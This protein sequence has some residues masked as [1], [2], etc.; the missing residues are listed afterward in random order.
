MSLSLPV[1]EPSVF[2]QF[3]SVPAPRIIS[4]LPPLPEPKSSK[5][6]H[7]IRDERRDIR[8]LHDIGWSYK[9]IYDYLPFHPTY[10]QIKYACKHSS[11]DT[12]QKK[13]GRRPALTQAQVE[14][15]VFF[16]C[17]SSQ[18]RR[19]SF[20]QLA[21]AMDF[22]VKKDAIRSALLRKGFPPSFGY[23]KASDFREESEA[24]K[25]LGRRAY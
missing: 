9:Q 13:T 8:L 10:D 11:R 1:I 5:S 12:P 24:P 23:T 15:L 21:T 18:N 3:P 25:G 14:D 20:A 4:L 16:V 6:A 2:Y 7:T 17:A 22:G 19:M